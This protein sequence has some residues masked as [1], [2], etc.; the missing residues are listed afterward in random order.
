MRKRPVALA[1]G[2]VLL[3]GCF[4]LPEARYLTFQ[5]LASSRESQGQLLLFVEKYVVRE[6]TNTHNIHLERFCAFDVH[7]GQKYRIPFRTTIEQIGSSRTRTEIAFNPK[8]A[9]LASTIMREFG[10]EERPTKEKFVE[11]KI[12]WSYGRQSSAVILEAQ[13]PGRPETRIVTFDRYGGS[14]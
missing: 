8:K 7:N 4:A 11:A 1:I 6:D 14:G 13:P 10:R 5:D 9:W 2:A 3:S 12:E